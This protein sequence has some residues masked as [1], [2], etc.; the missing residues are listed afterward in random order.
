METKT[1]TLKCPDYRVG[2]FV[3][4]APPNDKSVVPQ[5][6]RGVYETNVQ[7]LFC[8]IVEEGMSVCDVGANFGQHTALFS[9]L[10]GK[11]GRVFAVEASQINSQYVRQ[12]VVANACGNVDVIGRGVWSHDTELTF[13]HVEGAEAT[14]FCSTKSDI[15]QI[16]P[17]PACKYQTIS[18]SPLDDLVAV[19]VDFAKFDIEGAELF[20][21]KGASRMLENRP[22][23]LV[24]INSFTY[25]TFTDVE[26][27]DMIDYM[28]EFGY[29]H[30]YAYVNNQW[31]EV[32]RNMILAMFTRQHMLIDVL[33][34]TR[35]RKSSDFRHKRRR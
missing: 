2:S 16:E 30:M 19:P 13:S 21:V 9:K 23:T 35:R 25:K 5:F 7:K 14:S 33:F 34:T 29:S 6:E 15:R 17:N 20:A 10:V 31:L 26:I 22:P 3:V 4:C 1:Y 27:S 32:T 24:E 11:D 8:G 12:T 18:V 28:L